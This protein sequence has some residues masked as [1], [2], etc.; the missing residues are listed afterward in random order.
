M[1][2][3]AGA[4]T[5]L[6]VSPIEAP[7][8]RAA[9][10]RLLAAGCSIRCHCHRRWAAP[11][12][13]SRPRRTIAFRRSIRDSSIRPPDSLRRALGPLAIRASVRLED[14]SAEAADRGPWIWSRRQGGPGGRTQARRTRS[15]ASSRRAGAESL[16]RF[17]HLHLRRFSTRHSALSTATGCSG[18]TANVHAEHCWRHDWWPV[19]NSWSLSRHESADQLPDQLHGQPFEQSVRSVR[20]GSDRCDASRRLFRLVG[21]PDR[22]NNRSA[23]SRQPDSIEPYRSHVSVAAGTHPVAKSSWKRSEPS[24]VDNHRHFPGYQSP[25]H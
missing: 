5:I 12:P 14:R 3:D 19:E 23:V 25:S 16:S 4:T 8:R 7:T 11:P 20:D 13:R 9:S 17:G 24:H 15:D 21:R 6:D 22:S 2:P 18:Y 1:Q 10:R